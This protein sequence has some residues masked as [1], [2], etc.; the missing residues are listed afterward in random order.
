[1][2]EDFGGLNDA[3]EIDQDGSD[4]TG[5]IGA[6]DNATLIGQAAI[7]VAQPAPGQNLPIDAEAGQRYI[8]EFSP[9]AAQVRVQGNDLI[10]EFPDGGSVT[11]NDLGTVV[12]Q[13]GAPVF[14]VAGQ[15]ISSTVIF[16]QA[17]ALAGGEDAPT[18]ETAAA[19][20]AVGTGETRYDDDTG[21]LIDLLDAQPVIPGVEREFRLIDLEPSEVLALDEDNPPVDHDVDVTANFIESLADAGLTFADGIGFGGGSGG[22][23]T[24]T[25][26]FTNVGGE[27]LNLEDDETQSVDLNFAFPFLGDTYTAITVSSN[28]FI[29]LGTSETDDDCCDADDAEFLSDPPRIAPAWYDLDPGESGASITVADLGDSIVVTWQGVPEFSNDDGN[30]FQVQLFSDGRIVFNYETLNADTSGSGHFHDAII[31]VTGGNGASDPG[32]TDLSPFGSFSTGSQGTVYEFFERDETDGSDN[33]DL[34]GQTIVFTPNGSGGW[35]VNTGP[36]SGTVVVTGDGGVAGPSTGDAGGAIFVTGHD[37]EEHGNAEYMNA[38]LD[39]LAF[40]HQATGAELAE[41]GDFSIAFL[42]GNL[43][44]FALS[45]MEAGGWDVTMYDL[46]FDFS[47]AFNGTF[48]LIMVG[49]GDG[50]SAHRDALFNAASD[51]E[52]FINGGGGLFINTDEDF[53]Q[54]WYDFVPNFGTTQNNSIGTSGIFTPTAAGNDIG[55]TE[56]IVDRDITHSFYTG[57]DTELFTVFELTQA[58]NRGVPAG[59]PVAF[60]TRNIGISDGEFVRADVDASTGGFLYE[61]QVGEAEIVDDNI[62]GTDVEDGVTTQFTI[63]SLPTDANGNPVGFLLIDR[64]DDNVIEE[65]VGPGFGGV[66][67]NVQTGDSVFYFLPKEDFADRPDVVTFNYFTT[68]SDGL[69]SLDDGPA[70]V[71]INLPDP[72]PTVSATDAS[73]DEDDIDGGEGGQT[74]V[75]GEDPFQI[76]GSDTHNL[77]DPPFDPDASQSPPDGFQST[78]VTGTITASFSF[79]EPGTATFTPATVAALQALNLTSST[80]DEALGYTLS[81]GNR[82]LTATTGGGTVF[83]LEIAPSSSSGDFEYSFVLLGSINHP[84]TDD[85]ATVDVETKFEDPSILPIQFQVTDL[86][87]DTANGTFNVTIVDDVPTIGFDGAEGQSYGQAPGELKLW[88]SDIVADG[89]EGA[90][91]HES[92]TVVFGADGPE[93]DSSAAPYLAL[94]FLGARALAEGPGTETE[95]VYDTDGSTANPALTSG[96]E[97]VT[98]AGDASDPTVIRGF[99][100]NDGSGDYSIGDDLVFTGHVQLSGNDPRHGHLTFELHRQLDHPDVDEVMEDDNIRFELSV[101]VTDDDGDSDTLGFTVDVDDDGPQVFQTQAAIVDEDGLPERTFGGGTGGGGT[102][103]TIGDTTFDLGADAFPSSVTLISGGGSIFG[104]VTGVEALTGGDINTAIFNLDSGD[105]FE[106]TFPVPIVNQTGDDLYFTDTRFDARGIGFSLDGG[107]T[108]HPVPPGDF[109]DTGLNPL[110]NGNFTPDLFAVTIDLSDFGVAAGASFD[111]IQMRG[112]NGTDPVVVGNL[113]AAGGGTGTGEA[114]VFPA[115]IAGGLGDIPD[116]QPGGDGN[117]ATFAGSLGV[118][119]GADRPGDISFAALDGQAVVNTD[120]DPVLSHGLPLTYSWDADTHTLTAFAQGG[121]DEGGTGGT[122]GSV[123]ITGHDSDEHENYDYDGAGLDYLLFGGA[124][125]AAARAG[126]TVALLHNGPDLDGSTTVAEYIADIQAAKGYDVTFF[127]LSDPSWTDVFAGG[128]DVI[129]AASIEDFA[130]D[131]PTPA[132]Q[133]LAQA[134]RDAL[135]GASDQ[136]ADYINDGGGLFIHTDGGFGQTWYDFIPNFGTA[137]NNTIDISG[138]FTPTTAGADIGLTEAIVDSDVTHSF[139]TGID[140]NLFTVFELTDA[141][142]SGVPVGLPVAFGARGIGIED[143]EF[144]PLGNPIFEIEIT[145]VQNGDYTLTLLNQVDHDAPVEP[146]TADENDIFLNLPF[147][148]TDFD[149]DTAD[150]T[151]PVTINDDSP[152]VGDMILTHDE[153]PGVDADADDVASSSKP[154]GL[155]AVLET[156]FGG[157]APAELS[158]AVNDIEFSFGADGPGTIALDDVADGTVSGLV[159][160]ATG[161]DIL[162]FNGPDNTIVGRVAPEFLAIQ[163][164]E[165]PQT[166]EGDVAFVVYLQ[167]GGS[168]ADLWFVQY[169]AIVHDNPADPDEANPEPTETVTG[170]DGRETTVPLFEDEFLEVTYTATDFD[171][172]AVQGTATI[173]IEDDGPAILDGAE[174]AIRLVHDESAGQQNGLPATATEDNNDDDLAPAVVEAQVLAVESWVGLLKGDPTFDLTAIGGVRDTIREGIHFDAGADGL[175]EVR[176]DLSDVFTGAETDLQASFDDAPVHAVVVD[177]ELILGVTGFAGDDASGRP[178]FDRVVFSLHMETT[179]TGLGAGEAEFTFVQYEAVVHP[180]PGDGSGTPSTFDEGL[181]SIDGRVEI[182]YVVEDKDGDTVST[183]TNAQI[184]VDIEDDGP[185]LS[186]QTEMGT[187][188]E[189]HLAGGNEDT[190]PAADQDTLDPDGAGPL[191]DDFNA[192]TTVASGSLAGLVNFGADQPGTFSL[193]SDFSGLPALTSNGE[194]VLYGFVPNPSGIQNPLIGFVD[195]ADPP[196]DSR[197]GVFDS[198]DRLVFSL[199]LNPNGT[200]IFELRDQLDHHPVVLADDAEGI[201][202]ID[203]S[204][205]VIATDADG[206]TVA[207][208]EGSFTID[209]IDDVPRAREDGFTVDEDGLTGGNPGGPGDTALAVTMPVHSLFGPDGG[210]GADGP[211]DID[212]ASL[213]GTTADALSGITTVPLTSR[214]DAITYDWDGTS[215]TLTAVADQGGADERPVFTLQVTNLNAGIVTFELLEAVDHPLTDDPGTAGTVETAYEDDLRLNLPFTVTDFDGD[216]AAHTLQVVIDDDSPVIFDGGEGFVTHDETPGVQGITFD[217]DFDGTATPSPLDDRALPAALIALA[218]GTP[219]GAAASAAGAFSYSVGADQPGGLSLTQDDGAAFDGIDSGLARSSDDTPIFLFSSSDPSVVLGRAGAD[220]AA[221]ETG[222]IVFAVHVDGSDDSLWFVQYD[223]V[224]HPNALNPNDAVVMADEFFLTVTDEDGDAVTAQEPF[225]VAIFDDG[226][227]VSGISMINDETAGVDHADDTDLTAPL[228]AA[229]LAEIAPAGLTP[230]NTSVKS[231]AFDYGADGPGGIVLDNVVDG[232][233]SG[234]IDT[235][236]GDSIFLFNRPD[237]VVVGLALADVSEVPLVLADFADFIGDIVFAA[238]IG[239]PSAPSGLDNESSADLWFV[240]Y[241]AIQHDNPFDHDEAG[242]E[243][244][245]G[246]FA[247]TPDVINFE[248]LAA[249]TFDGTDGVVDGTFGV[250]SVGGRT[251]LVTGDNPNA[252][253]AGAR[254]ANAAVIFDSADPSRGLFGLGTPNEDFGGPGIGAGGESGSPFQNDTALGKTLI[255]DRDLINVDGDPLH[256]DDP[257]VQGVVVSF[258]TLDFLA[259]GPVTMDSLDVMD[260]NNGQTMTIRMFDTGDNLLAA[261]NAPGTDVNGVATVDLGGTPG[262]VRVLMTINGSAAV[263]NIVFRPEEERTFEDE[264]LTLGYSV[265][266]AD[267]DIVSAAATISIEDD[268]PIANGDTPS[269]I[270]DD[271]S[272]SVGGNVFGNDVIGADGPVVLPDGP[273]TLFKYNGEDSVGDAVELT[274]AAGLTVMTFA[275]GDLT[276]NADGAWMYVQGG[277]DGLSSAGYVDDFSYVIEDGDG[278]T[279]S[280]IQPIRVVLDADEVAINSTD[281]VIE[282]F[283]LDDF[284]AGGDNA[285]EIAGNGGNDLLFGGGGG[286]TLIAGAGNDQLFGDGGADAFSFSLAANEGTNTIGDFS[287]TEGDTLEFTDVVADVDGIAGIGAGDAIDVTSFS[288]TGSTVTVDLHSGTT[289][290]I[291]DVNGAIDTAQDLLDNSVIV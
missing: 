121:G 231:I 149:G 124:A 174:G 229:F 57:V 60:G 61:F 160:T 223:A 287:V 212:F 147:L 42:N 46:D 257:A 264:T 101:T 11:F 115:G 208:G 268:G 271:A 68:D 93:T 280:T 48:D 199:H 165:G 82:T 5:L 248:T 200:Y 291:E 73:V 28:G 7:T 15:P 17:V 227:S 278:D 100:D 24:Q 4:E 269:Y 250:A 283:G 178:V 72:V 180:L 193:S 9:D 139:Y 170:R 232:T 288:K 275:G 25:F 216:A 14:E 279:A 59:L 107:A 266:D 176:F 55:L 284:L 215:H 69:D 221:A 86:N 244:G 146:G 235:E 214:G 2:T 133:A 117:E 168:E 29:W 260:L 143:G 123:F 188:E 125:D 213:H 81:N 183:P 83:T 105:V 65:I 38:G 54:S 167:D 56:A 76:P 164:E 131:N 34:S 50:R 251:I 253:G 254:T 47:D 142:T 198:D 62:H 171:G 114:I 74:L 175:G 132:E 30:T 218:L 162:L 236:T 186:G 91:A 258:L 99:I 154:A 32:E 252:D 145:D 40:G 6:Q 108:W 245:T 26:G 19:P 104:G 41:R 177:G 281:A 141:N 205:V 71:T 224:E 239:A 150:G 43:D 152:S 87:G 185:K 102:P 194:P 159:D 267:G 33:F 88:E 22:G 45:R 238:V 182:G 116:P 247:G 192:T 156:V 16:G 49:S 290:I 113:N 179:A 136:F 157:T 119:F 23:S 237:G 272:G 203:F 259:G 90:L 228:P 189:E 255:I 144:V 277:G 127:D 261:Y 220:A 51:F 210:F 285:N 274:A 77:G 97:M 217:V 20:G 35:E 36:S 202:P 84:L 204:S 195:V 184:I 89:G 70:T 109:V 134:S 52:A 249:G 94:N 67:V 246:R 12:G 282:G 8:I 225:F 265:T 122:G 270:Q 10:L 206:D 240:Q 197:E 222:D 85:P 153:T 191:G 148:V 39:F 137:V 273:V 233:D 289:L 112:N 96:G 31:G 196:G 201:L 242:P 151:L 37:S 27:P 92:F 21:Q 110:L 1:M 263:D 286:D 63:T 78:T 18:F 138:I 161:R 129:M 106:L 172:D 234:L 207:L 130:G 66:P 128:F 173:T 158:A 64:G 75:P 140:T 226:P 98:V 95:I 166:P 211:G 163:I 135:F 155:L 230:I 190:S 181:V 262:V 79:D 13:P 53:G 120:G 58:N 187:V 243:G 219:I 111:T 3:S 103:V 126:K 44:T 276:V 169:S 209:V 118:D 241:T 80:N 256:I